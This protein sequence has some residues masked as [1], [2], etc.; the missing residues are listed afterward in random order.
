MATVTLPG[1]GGGRGQKKVCVPKID[2]QIRAPFDK[3]HFV[4]EEQLSDVGGGLGFGEG[5]QA[6]VPPP[7]PASHGLD[8][9]GVAVNILCV[10]SGGA[11]A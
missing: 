10:G 1:G 6:A 3:S 5:A 2:L 7:P 11:A 9:F 4:P 8:P